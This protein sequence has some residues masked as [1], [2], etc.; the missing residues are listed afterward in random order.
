MLN[1]LFRWIKKRLRSFKFTLFRYFLEFR[2]TEHVFVVSM[3]VLI[4]LLGGF[5]AVGIQKLI[6][7][8]EHT[9][10]GTEGFPPGY[11][12]A[13]PFYVKLLVPAGGGLLVGLMVYY[14][15]REA[16][17]HGVPEVMQAI[18]LKNG[19]IRPR[20]AIVKLL[21]SSLCIGSGG[22][23]GRE[24]PVIQIGSAIG[25]AIGQ[26]LR[27]NPERLK[28]F[29]ACGASAGIAAAFNAP[30]AGAIFSAEVILCDFTVAQFSPIVIASVVGTVVSRRFLG[31][32]PA[33]QVPKYELLSPYEL[34]FYAILG[35]I[36]GLVALAYIRVLYKFEDMFEE[37]RIP[38]VAKTAIGGLLVGGIGLFM[39]QI[40]GVGY[41]TMDQA[42]HG[43]MVSPF[44]A[45]WLWLF[46]LL[47]AFVKILATSLSLG[48]GG[49]GGIFAPSLFIGTMIGGFFGEVLNR[50]FP[51]VAANPGA[52]ALV[53]MGALVSGT[54]HAPITAILIIF[55]MT[56][57]YKIILP[58]MITCVIS[59]L[60][61][62]KLERESIYTLKL[63]R[64][65]IKLS[66]GREVNIL[67]SIPV[68]EV[69]REDPVV[70]SS[71]TPFPKLIDLFFNSQHSQF[72]VVD[73][74]EHLVGRLSLHDVRR[75][76]QEEE[77]L[78]HL[79]VAYDLINPDVAQVYTDDT[80]DQVMRI[81]GRHD[82]EELPVVD[83]NN[84]NRIIGVVV[85]KDV[86]E[87][88]NREL[89]RRDLLSETGA[90]LQ[91]LE[92]VRQVPVLDGY[93]MAEIPVPLSFTGKTLQEL[94]LRNRFG[95]NILMIKR[96]A[97][98]G[99]EQQIIPSPS[100]RIETGDVLIALGRE[101]D[102][103]RLRRM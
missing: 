53:G 52:Y 67:Q 66:E 54:T 19:V 86:I 92:K 51:G 87:A 15:A 72:F 77:Y 8:F 101:K 16:K 22:S 1:R 17:G 2:S 41:P 25:S 9:F 23:V 39:P 83:R 75:L 95:V 14:L 78:A 103:N 93:A 76:L 13:L 48:S 12:A 63:A 97:P 32:Y 64:R 38:E 88:Y 60:L 31:N 58:L 24:G 61:A 69:M 11:I 50:L 43:S 36:A 18:A 42:L 57:D 47:L 89:R 73:E 37:W 5:G 80:L 46:L 7:L 49:S 82:A 26:F 96:K 79:I 27:V 91:M 71:A 34:F 102:L 44:G 68:K 10:W 21:A 81:F 28:T 100:E 98:D 55:E 59:T 3:A 33:F 94:E 62:T 90:T 4:G 65:G 74:Q 35:L 45:S 99:S 56:G 29:V 85:Y 30:V 40:F 70:I 20:V 6:K 84:P